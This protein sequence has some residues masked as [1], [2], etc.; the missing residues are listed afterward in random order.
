MRCVGDG[1]LA[2]VESSRCPNRRTKRETV[3][4]PQVAQ[5]SLHHSYRQKP[6][7]ISNVARVVG[8]YHEMQCDESKN[9]SDT[10]SSRATKPSADFNSDDSAK[11]DYTA[12]SV[13]CGYFVR[14]S[15]K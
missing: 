6:V 2:S 10:P 5:R 3:A 9:R 13:D 12:C 8:V 7:G 15:Y 4:C 11:L 14:C 1:N